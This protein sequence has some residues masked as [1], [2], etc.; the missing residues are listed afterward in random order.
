MQAEDLGDDGLDFGRMLGGAADMDAALAI[1]FGPGGLR[2]QIEMIL[3][4]D[5]EFAF[6]EV[7][8]V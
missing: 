6:E 2:F 7:R 1:G 3:A 5:V 8:A 4:T